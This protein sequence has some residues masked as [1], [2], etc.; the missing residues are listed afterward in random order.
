MAAWPATRSCSAW[1]TRPRGAARGGPPSR[2]GRGDRPVG[3]P[4]PDQQRAGLPWDLPRRLRRRCDR[5]H[6]GHEAGRGQALAGLVGDD[7]AEDFI[8]PSPFDPRVGPPR[9][10]RGRRGRPRGRGREG[11]DADVS[12][13]RSLWLGSQPC[14]PCTP[15]RSAPTT[16]C[17][18][19]WS[20][21]RPDP[22]VP[23]GWTTVTVKAAAL[24]HHDLWTLR[25]V[26]LPEERLPMILGCDAAGVDED[27]NEV[28]VH[29]VISDPALAR[30]RDA[31]PEAVAA[32]R[33]VPGHVRRPGRGASRATSCP[34]RPRCQL[35]GGRLPADGLADGVP[36]ALHPGRPQARRDAFSC[37][38]PAAA[39]PPH[40]SRSPGPPGCGCGSPAA[41]RRSGSGRSSSARTRRSRPARG[42][43][44]ASTR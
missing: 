29:A 35:R 26:G 3:L 14:S 36:D 43:P 28:V 32:L 31:R 38:A 19:W 7:L 12:G 27:G 44:S 33:A 13:R 37:R 2:A 1:P 21:E 18:G 5:D 42:C 6:R 4:E 39:S 8:V 17:A 30:R 24:N 16:R 9:C 34:S 41:T 25:G 10:R 23:D 15:R 11:T 22:E 40:W 20:G